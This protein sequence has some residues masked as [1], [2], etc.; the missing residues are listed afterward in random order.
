MMWFKPKEPLILQQEAVVAGRHVSLRPTRLGLSLLVV[1]AGVWVGAANYQV[2]VAYLIC[3]WIACFVGVGALLTRRQL[4]GL[5]MQIDYS[6]EVFA[7]QVA[8]VTLRLVDSGSRSRLFWWRGEMADEVQED[9]VQTRG[10][11]QYWRVSGSL[12]DS[13]LT[14]IW[15]IPVF[16]RGYF[17]QPLLLRLASSAPF[18]LFTA[19][20]RVEW[21][22]QAVVYPAPLEHSDFGVHPAVDPEQTPQQAGMHGD[23]IAYLKNHQAGASLQHVAWKVYAKRGD[24]MDKVFDEPPPVLHSETISYHDYPIG[25]PK[26]KLANL[27]TYRVLQAERMGAPYTLE[28]PKFSIAPQNQQ[29]EKSLNALALM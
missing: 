9:D 7:G 27:M 3:F 29:R 17:P 19:E 23:D 5:H 15:A 13:E 12:K 28:L 16:Q 21:Q 18:G 8:Q 6:G 4:L 20:C 2:N 14:Q 26:D 10:D 25:T 24:L 1:S 11:W 22:T